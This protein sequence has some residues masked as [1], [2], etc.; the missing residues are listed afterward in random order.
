MQLSGSLH[1]HSSKDTAGVSHDVDVCG[2][3]TFIISCMV[4][5][6]VNKGRMFFWFF[7]AQTKTPERE[8]L[9]I[10]M[11]GKGHAHGRVSSVSAFDLLSWH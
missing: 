11:T 7:E 10:W 5:M 8:P 3:C 4:W 6:Q 1:A 2:S 9:V